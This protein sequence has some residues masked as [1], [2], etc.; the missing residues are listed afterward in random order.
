MR[1]GLKMLGSE[2]EEM[3]NSDVVRDEGMYVYREG[4]L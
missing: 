4:A 2:Q 1:E 3:G